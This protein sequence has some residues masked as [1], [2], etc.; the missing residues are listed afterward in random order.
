MYY[1]LNTVYTQGFSKPRGLTTS[2]EIAKWWKK[3]SAEGDR[4][5][6]TLQTKP[7]KQAYPEEIT[8]VLQLTESELFVTLSN[9]SERVPTDRKA[10]GGIRLN[11]NTIMT[12]EK[13]CRNEETRLRISIDDKFGI[14][15]QI[16]EMDVMTQ[17]RSS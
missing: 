13:P 4:N 5:Y 6:K 14:Y 17:G 10:E 8:S 9:T 3:S 15:N 12:W 1:L 2:E 16:A 7:E 11:K